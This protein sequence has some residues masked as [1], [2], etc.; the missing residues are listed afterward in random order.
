MPAKGGFRFIA[1][2]GFG[3]V[4]LADPVEVQVEDWD[5]HLLRALAKPLSLDN[6]PFA[7]WVLARLAFMRDDLVDDPARSPVEVIEDA[8]FVI[9]WRVE[10]ENGRVVAKLQVQGGM[11]GVGL[12]GVQER[13]LTTSLVDA[14][15]TILV[16]L[17]EQLAP[18]CICVRDPAW[19]DWPDDF[20]PTPGPQTVNAYGWDGARFLGADNVRP[21]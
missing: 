8:L 16:E 3:V 21:R 14:L 5:A 18:V 9:D 2:D 10:D 12:L 7:S 4:E 19:T 13:D 20:T 1:D 17:P 6:S 15:T 11:V